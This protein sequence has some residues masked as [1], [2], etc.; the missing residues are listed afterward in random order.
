MNEKLALLSTIEL[1]SSLSCGIIILYLTYR[2]LR[3]Y[4][5]KKLGIDQY[6]TAY[7][8]FISAVLLSVGIVMGGVIGPILSYFRI[9]SD[10]DISGINL[11]VSFIVTG[12][13]YIFI[14]Y[15]LTISVIAIGIGLYTYMTPL[16]EVQELKNNNIGVAIVL[17]SIIISELYPYSTLIT[18][19][20]LLSP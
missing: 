10:T 17:T 20:I 18:E 19:C 12:G 4:G 7:L 15:L 2:L 6:N 5:D 9:V 16:K 11:F 1:L 13:A 14:S 3:I 8:I